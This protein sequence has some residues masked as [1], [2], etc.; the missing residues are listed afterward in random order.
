[1]QQYYLSVDKGSTN[2]KVVL[3]DEQ[4]NQVYVRCQP[5]ITLTPEDGWREFELEQAWQHL[6]DLIRTT[7]TDFC[8]PDQIK[9][10][11][12]SSHGNGLI[13]LDAN[14]EAC[15]NGIYSLDNRAFD[16]FTQW[17]QAGLVD[18]ACEQI[19]FRF[20][21]GSVMPLY[22]WV[23]QNRP[24]IHSEVAHVLFPKDWLRFRL[25]GELASDYT[26]AS[27]TGVLH[28]ENQTYASDVFALLGIA[29]L[30]EK[31]LPL[32]SAT[33]QAG[34][35]TS[36]AAQECGLIAGT[37]VFVGA[38]DL[39]VTPAGVA[40]SSETTLSSTFGTWS[41]STFIVESTPE[42]PLIINHAI[43]GL[44][45]SGV[46]DGN[47]GAAF[48]TMLSLCFQDYLADHEAGISDI[49]ARVEQDVDPEARNSLLFV[50]HLFGSAIDTSATASLLGLK[51]HTSRAE[52][53]KSVIEGIVLGY[54]YNLSLFPQMASIDK[55][56]LT[57]GGSLSNV[58]PQIM[59][60]VFQ[61][62]VFTSLDH[63]VTARGA[64]VCAQLGLGEIHS[65]DEAK[66][67]RIRKHFKPNVQLQRYYQS[68]ASMLAE[69]IGSQ[70]QLSQ[71]LATLINQ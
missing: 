58:I 64:A 51:A 3:F 68:K 39:C 25:T 47:A 4:L 10:V 6:C 34:V 65:L 38:H 56:W 7:V 24:S 50:P 46:G 71:G 12:F 16:V 41:I 53:L 14:G 15:M 13:M 69:A 35:V 70:K 19:R 31:L 33:D 44:F 61:C 62:P 57:G 22:A 23:S 2:L 45:I 36:K 37:P 32:K 63:E 5:N 54:Y 49:H 9:A 29:D 48:D 21:H 66:P 27:G 60:D 59:A 42:I 55:I 11:S 18:K 1:M 28:H 40:D 52:I 17:Q 43:P 26:D 8:R 20:D 30:G 67:P